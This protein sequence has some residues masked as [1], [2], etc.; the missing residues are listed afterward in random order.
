LSAYRLFCVFSGQWG[1]RRPGGAPAECAV[2]STDPTSGRDRHCHGPREATVRQAR[3]RPQ[4]AGRRA[5][6]PLAE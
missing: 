2:T 3:R 1:R 6:A 5:D 4:P